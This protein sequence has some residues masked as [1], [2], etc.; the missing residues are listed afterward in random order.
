MKKK[1]VVIFCEGKAVYGYMEKSPL[2]DNY[3]HYES[4]IDKHIELDFTKGKEYN[5]EVVGKWY[6]TY[7]SISEKQRSECSR[8]I[9]MIVSLDV[10][11]GRNLN[12]TAKMF[13]EADEKHKVL[14]R[15][16]FN[17][18]KNFKD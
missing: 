17:V 16:F 18:N 8:L 9:L 14:I 3:Q 10:T 2:T 6:K 7:S 12:D 15:D 11:Y 1:I 13:M 5:E 4:A